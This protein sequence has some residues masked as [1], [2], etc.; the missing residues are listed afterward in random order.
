MCW[1]YEPIIERVRQFATTWLPVVAWAA[2]IFTLSSIPS[3]DSGLGTLDLVLR[4]I[5]HFAEFAVLGALLARVLDDVPA[6]LV[7]VAYAVTDEV[8]QAFVQGREGAAM[9]VAIDGAGVLA[10]VFVLRVLAVQS[11]R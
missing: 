11:R 3:L 7:G 8:H 9:D 6:V 4:K 10:G 1:F 5:A 2:L